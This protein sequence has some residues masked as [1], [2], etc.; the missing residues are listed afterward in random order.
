MHSETT[1]NPIEIF[2]VTKMYGSLRAVD[3]VSFS[4]TSGEIFSLL[5]PNG[6]G[7]TTLIEILEGLRRKDEGDV[8]VLG[9]DPWQNGE[10]LHRQVGV[11]PQHF[12]S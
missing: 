7:K 12:T 5:G 10:L 11:I 1:L 8:N 3:D 4:L 2:H 6:A 9:C